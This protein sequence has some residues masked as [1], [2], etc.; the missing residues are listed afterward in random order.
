MLREVD[1]M[2]GRRSAERKLFLTETSGVEG[3]G[4]TSSACPTDHPG[5]ESTSRM[6]GGDNYISTFIFD[7]I[8]MSMD[9]KH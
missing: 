8:Y 1:Q 4:P 5:G 2:P 9:Y 7:L 3:P 6:V